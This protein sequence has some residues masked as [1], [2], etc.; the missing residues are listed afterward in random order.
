MGPT[1]LGQMFGDPFVCVSNQSLDAF[2]GETWV[3]QLP[4]GSC[5]A[6]TRAVMF[7][8]SFS[9][10]AL[11]VVVMRCLLDPFGAVALFL[12]R[13]AGAAERTGG[14]GQH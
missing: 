3:L 6:L 5:A 9:E 4:A 12:P 10:I 1:A 8:C 14:V 2:S 13:L 11:V 7:P